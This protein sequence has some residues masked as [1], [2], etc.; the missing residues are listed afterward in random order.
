MIEYMLFWIVCSI[1]CFV[2]LFNYYQTKFPILANEDYYKDIIFC[3]IMSL[4][5]PVT[6]VGF[7]IFRLI[8]R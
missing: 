4:F 1:V 7:I 8:N 2:I 5:G 3:F 6:L